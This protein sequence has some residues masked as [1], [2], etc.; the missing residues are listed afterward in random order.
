MNPLLSCW[1]LS[2]CCNKLECV[3]VEYRWFD[4]R[5]RYTSGVWHR[6]SRE[7]VLMEWGKQCCYLCFFWIF[8]TRDSERQT[9]GTGQR[10]VL[11]HSDEKEQLS[12]KPKTNFVVVIV[13][14]SFARVH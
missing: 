7:K 11:Q 4:V 8:S 9:T 12:C 5:L 3:G 10:H 6:S 2:S 14:A 1:Q 13:S